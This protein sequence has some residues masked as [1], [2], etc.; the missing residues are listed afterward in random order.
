MQNLTQVYWPSQGVNTIGDF[1]NTSGYVVKVTQDVDFEICGDGLAPGEIELDTGWHYLPVL[2]EC[3]VNAMELFGNNLDDIVIVQDLIGTDVFWPAMEVYTLEALISGKAYKMKTLGQ[4]NLSFPLCL[5]KAPS[6]AIKPHNTFS[7][8]WG[9]LNI[10]PS[11]QL[12]AFYANALEI[13]SE[14]DIIGAF[15]QDGNLYGC[16]EIKDKS[17]NQVITLFGDDPMTLARD[18]YY[19]GEPI[20]FRVYQFSTGGKTDIHVEYDQS[21]DNPSDKYHN[22]SLSAVSRALLLVNGTLKPPSATCQIYPNP[23][24]DE[25]VVTYP[26]FKYQDQISADIFNTRGTLVKKVQLSD[27]A[28]SVDVSDLQ[29]GVYFLKISSSTGFIVKKLI[30]Q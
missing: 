9:P 22:N 19:E 8:P 2:S 17:Q 4:I 6:A 5:G 12:V 20:Q 23:A 3:E 16:M 18:G 10:T 27:N 13:F 26:D 11:S 21:M 15:G 1:S 14:G 24:K 30:V 25:F 7:T 28:T 29:Q